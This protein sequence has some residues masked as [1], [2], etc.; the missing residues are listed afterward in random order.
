VFLPP[1]SYDLN[2]IKLVFHEVKHFVRSKY[3]MQISLIEERLIEGFCAVNARNVKAYY[4]HCGY[5]KYH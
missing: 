5:R 4:R 2:P 1:Y 3:G